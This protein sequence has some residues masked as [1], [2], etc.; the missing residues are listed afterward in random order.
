MIIFLRCLLFPPLQCG[1]KLAEHWTRFFN[2]IAVPRLLV[3]MVKEFQVAFQ[4]LL[5]CRV[6]GKRSV[7]IAMGAIL[8][9]RC[10]VLV[11]AVVLCGLHMHSA[12]LAILF[13]HDLSLQRKGGIE[14][15]DHYLARYGLR[16]QTVIIDGA[17]LIAMLPAL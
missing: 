5:H 1:Q 14:G 2:R 7:L 9:V 15:F 10:S 3:P 6:A 4:H 13:V 17:T 16:F 11:R 8:M 12:A